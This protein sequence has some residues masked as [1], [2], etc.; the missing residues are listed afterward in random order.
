VKNAARKSG[1]WICLA[2]VLLCG[3]GMAANLDRPPYPTVAARIHTELM[4][5]RKSA[6]NA[7]LERRATL[8][9]VAERRAEQVAVRPHK[10]RLQDAAPIGRTFPGDDHL[11][12]RTTERMILLKEIAPVTGVLEKWESLP[13]AW[14]SLTQ[15][16]W[17][18]IGYGT[19]T[20]NDGWYIFI[21]I[22][23]RDLKI[24]DSPRDIYQAEQFVF[25]SINAI[26]R[27]HDLTDLKLSSNLSKV[28][29]KHS[30]E[31]ADFDRFAHEGL[32]GTTPAKRVT[33]AG[34]RYAGVAENITMN[35]NPEEAMQQAVRDWMDSPGHRKNIL[36]RRFRTT[37]VGV[38]VSEDG[39]YY[40]TQLFLFDK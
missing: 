12:R 21:A 16:E 14:K 7:I 1:A 23:A 24:R 2:V 28:A 22:L 25:R 5:G 10:K 15:G 26:R 35:N 33:A 37:G 9:A 34:I 18:A 29:R 31:M 8:D 6:G 13:S 20:A 39:K 19:A 36:D 38:A 17:D 40:F 3:V 27:D 4:A 11:Y 32:G 30:R